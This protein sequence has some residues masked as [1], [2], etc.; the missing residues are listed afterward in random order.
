M[1]ALLRAFSALPA[2]SVPALL[3]ELGEVTR[4]L[5][6]QPEAQLPLAHLTLISGATFTGRV[7][8]TQQD[9]SGQRW[10][11]INPAE[12]DGGGPKDALVSLSVAQ[13]A[14]VTLENGARNQEV[15][16]RAGNRSVLSSPHPSV[17]EVRPTGPARV[18][19]STSEGLPSAVPLGRAPTRLELRRRLAAT[20]ET[21]S[22]LAESAILLD[23]ALDALPNQE[24]A[25]RFFLKA[26]DETF[27][28]L[29]GLLEQ[30]E[31]RY[32]AVRSGLREVRLVL[33]P[34]RG[35]SLENGVL[36]LALHLDSGEAG[37]YSSEALR[38]ALEQQL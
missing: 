14:A 26:I 5:R 21:L 30:D 33:S 4:Q 2:C 1:D 16:R 7:L 6:E 23:G 11:L 13:I 22:S 37:Y 35:L 32:Q 19:S 15:V 18:S 9:P 36:T 34:Q 38:H 24:E 27:A 8:A 12:L 3:D 20:S 28:A 10:V 29:A 31:M 25:H 17:S